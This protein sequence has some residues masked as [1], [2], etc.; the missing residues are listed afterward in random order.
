MTIAEVGLDHFAKDSASI[1]VQKIAEL[2]HPYEE[3]VRAYAE[4]EKNRC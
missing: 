3:A 1:D 4:N 2:L